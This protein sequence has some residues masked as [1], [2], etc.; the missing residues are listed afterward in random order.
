[1]SLLYLQHKPKFDAV[2]EHYRRAFLTQPRVAVTLPQ[3]NW[4]DLLT[5][6]VASAAGVAK[7]LPGTD[8]DRRAAVV[9]ATKDFYVQNL[10][11]I[12]A[13]MVGYP[14]VFDNVIEPAVENLIAGAAGGFYDGLAKILA[15]GQPQPEAPTDAPA[16]PTQPGGFI[17][18]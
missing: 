14:V 7:S 4:V 11:P 17:A 1:M 8:A 2:V 16:D 10:K 12:L 9:R 13:A 6:F 3:I 5:R 15:G 18:Y